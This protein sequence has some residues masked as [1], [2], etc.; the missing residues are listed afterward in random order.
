MCK[1]FVAHNHIAEDE[2]LKQ[3][4]LENYRSKSL[5]RI[6]CKIFQNKTENVIEIEIPNPR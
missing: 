1:V 5:E 2:L 4:L 6:K 3:Y